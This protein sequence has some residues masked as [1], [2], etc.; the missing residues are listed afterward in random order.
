MRGLKQPM[1]ACGLGH[2]EGFGVTYEG[3][4]RVETRGEAGMSE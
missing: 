4:K 1:S 2:D 3:L